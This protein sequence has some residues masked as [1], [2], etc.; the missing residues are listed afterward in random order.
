MGL[1][2]CLYV[3]LV[4]RIT[5]HWVNSGFRRGVNEIFDLRACYAA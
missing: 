3:V 4:F 1:S 5:D 2:V